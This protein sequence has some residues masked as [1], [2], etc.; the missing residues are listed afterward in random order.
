MLIDVIH[1]ETKSESIF[2]FWNY[3]FSTPNKKILGIFIVIEDYDA[4]KQKLKNK[5]GN[6]LFL[7][8]CQNNE[9]LIF[10]KNYFNQW[11]LFI[12]YKKNLIYHRS[13]VKKMFR[14]KE[15]RKEKYI[16]EAF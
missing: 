11:N 9:N 7:N 1:C 6:C 16:N 10:L 2:K 13:E 3:Y 12:V 8:S 5:Y 15:I 4:V 14:E